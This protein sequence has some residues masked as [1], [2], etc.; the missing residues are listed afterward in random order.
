MGRGLTWRINTKTHTHERTNEVGLFFFLV[1]HVRGPT[2]NGVQ[3]AIM[4]S[5]SSSRCRGVTAAL[6]ALT[7]EPIYPPHPHPTP[8]WLA[9]WLVSR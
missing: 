4:S 2:N 8:R 7:H 5:S 3:G 9:R 1:I 6:T